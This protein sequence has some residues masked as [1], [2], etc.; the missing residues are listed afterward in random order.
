MSIDSTEISRVMHNGGIL[1][2]E[3]FPDN[4]MNEDN[5]EQETLYPNAPTDELAIIQVYIK[6]KQF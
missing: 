4:Y 6:S 1:P 5:F 2:M 3:L